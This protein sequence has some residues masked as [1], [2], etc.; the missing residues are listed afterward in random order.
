MVGFIWP[1]ASP[2]T[3]PT[4]SA[5]LALGSS[6]TTSTATSTASDG[7]V[8]F[9]PG[10]AAPAAPTST[11]LD[12]GTFYSSS[13]SVSTSTA[14]DGGTF[15]SS[16]IL[17]SATSPTVV[18]STALD[19]GISYSSDVSTF[20]STASD[21]GT[22]FSSN[23]P[24]STVDSHTSAH[25]LPTAH[26]DNPL[27]P[28]VAPPIDAVPSFVDYS[29]PPIALPEVAGRAFDRGIPFEM[30]N[31]TSL[32]KDMPTG[33]SSV[34]TKRAVPRIASNPGPI[35][36]AVVIVLGIVLALFLSVKYCLRRSSGPH[37]LEKG[38]YPYTRGRRRYRDGS[39]SVT[40]PDDIP[41]SEGYGMDP[42]DLARAQNWQDGFSEKGVHVTRDCVYRA[43]SADNFQ[44]IPI[45]GGGD[46]GA[47]ISPQLPGSFPTRKLVPK[48]R[49]VT[50]LPVPSSDLR[51]LDIIDQPVCPLSSDDG[52]ID[53]NRTRDYN[54]V[55]PLD[56]PTMRRGPFGWL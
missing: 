45:S 12:S 4:N 24:T 31:L 21:G 33:L 38:N 54:N 43:I 56:S 42:V 34:L 1:G 55:S 6:S 48:P 17:A 22:L 30:P 52:Q 9:S 44:L 8:I 18:T 16:H 7:G 39:P 53:H 26:L 28:N 15:F 27:N 50:Q 3:A 19:S 25:C 46:G 36:G 41:I 40:R 5:S 14:S 11:A 49:P 2:S 32:G 47:Y 20:T 13:I 37:D 29:T 51:P 23:T 10:I 35:L